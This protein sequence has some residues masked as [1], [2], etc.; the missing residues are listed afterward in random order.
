[1]T[2]ARCL[3]ARGSVTRELGA[4]PSHAPYSPPLSTAA[5]PPQFAPQLRRP[6]AGDGTRQ[7]H[8][9]FLLGLKLRGVERRPRLPRRLE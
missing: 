1:M 6:V 4:A 9:A 8:T 5:A 7:S 2:E 3:R